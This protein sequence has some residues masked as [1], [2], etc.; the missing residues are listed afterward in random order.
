M[1]AKISHGVNK[2]T[3][4]NDVF[5]TPL[6][7]AKKQID[8]IESEEDDIW[9]DPFKNTGN[10]YNQYPTDKKVW[11]EILYDRDFFEFNGE[12]DIICSNPPYSLMTEIIAKCIELRPRVISFLLGMMNLTPK[13]IEDFNKAGY[14]ITKLRF[15]RVHQW[16][17]NS[18]I[19]QLELDKENVIDIDRKVYHLE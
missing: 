9:F 11:C 17:G 3:K 19:V 1:S 10:Y 5:I 8:M 13:R 12:C 7:L 4:A 18:F 15:L 6:D 16:Y 14:G 2:R